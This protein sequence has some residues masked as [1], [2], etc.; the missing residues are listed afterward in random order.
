MRNKILQYSHLTNE[1]LW[2]IPRQR[3]LGDVIN[4]KIRFPLFDMIDF[5]IRNTIAFELQREIINNENEKP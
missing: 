4:N 1:K 2:T 5:S 3:A